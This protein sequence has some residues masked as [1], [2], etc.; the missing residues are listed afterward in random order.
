MDGENRA[1]GAWFLA[2]ALAAWPPN[3]VKVFGKLRRRF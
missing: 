3:V 2:R 1:R